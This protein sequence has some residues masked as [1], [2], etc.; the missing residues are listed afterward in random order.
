MTV[1]IY[2]GDLGG[3]GHHPSFLLPSFPSSSSLIP[4]WHVLFETYALFMTFLVLLCLYLAGKW[5]NFC[6]FD[7]V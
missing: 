4:L 1:Y 5:S 7:F 6:Y 2:W 3:N